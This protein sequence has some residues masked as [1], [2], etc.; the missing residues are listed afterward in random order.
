MGNTVYSSDSRSIRAHNLGYDTKSTH[1]IFK[2]K[3]VNDAMSPYNVGIRESRDSET[4]PNSLAII[5]A[6]DETGSMHAIPHALVKRGLPE[7]MDGIIK[8]G[9]PD[10][11]VLFLGIGD[12]ECDRSPLQVGQFESGDEELDYW[13]THVYL[14]GGGGGNNGESYL[15]AWY[16]AAKHTSIDCWEKRKEKGILFTIGDEPCLKSIPAKALKELMGKGQFDMYEA[17][18]LLGMARETYDIYHIHM[19]EGSNGQRQEV[20]DGWTQMLGRENVFFAKRTEDVAKIITEVVTQ[21]KKTSVKP[22]KEESK[23]ML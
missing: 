2:E 19:M 8:Q 14:E 22:E 10:P 11:Q 6:L 17:G 5:I 21:R 7:I 12:H 23:V 16:F 13:L 20:K 15:L 9:I 3:K 1:E 18:E 4:H